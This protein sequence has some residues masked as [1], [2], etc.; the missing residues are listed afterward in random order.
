[1]LYLRNFRIWSA[2]PPQA[3][4]AEQLGMEGSKGRRQHHTPA[5]CDTPQGEQL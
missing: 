3:A 5:Q 2:A 4:E 1:M